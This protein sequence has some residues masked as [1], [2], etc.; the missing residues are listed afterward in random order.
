MNAH[1]YNLSV[2][3]DYDFMSKLTE[4]GTEYGMYRYCQ[5]DD[6]PD[7]LRMKL[8]ELFQYISS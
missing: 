4:A 8:G 6:G 7:A 3:H 1:N 2:D 5:P